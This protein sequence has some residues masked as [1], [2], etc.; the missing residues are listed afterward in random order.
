MG[1]EIDG[2]PIGF[3]T[4]TIWATEKKKTYYFPLYWLFNRDSYNEG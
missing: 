1:A 3:L 2:F 4:N